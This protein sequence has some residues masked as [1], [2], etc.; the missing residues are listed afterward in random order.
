MFSNVN[1]DCYG[2]S[3][4]GRKRQS[5]EDRFLI[6]DLSRH[7]NICETNLDEARDS[8]LAGDQPGKLFVVADGVGGHAGGAKASALVVQSICDFVLNSMH[9]FLKLADERDEDFRDELAAGIERCQRRLMLE[10][11][12]RPEY[13]DMATT[14]TL[15][16]LVWPRMYVVHVGDSRCYLLRDGHLEQLTTDHTVA[17]QFVDGGA[18]QKNAARESPW[19]HIIWNCLGGDGDDIAPEV[20]RVDLRPRDL[21]LL[22]TDGLTDKLTEEELTELLTSGQPAESITQALIDAANDRGGADNVT[23]I[24]GH[25]AGAPEAVRTCGT[26]GKQTTAAA[27]TDTHPDIPRSLKDE[28]FRRNPGAF[29]RTSSS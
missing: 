9:R 11:Q 8:D 15:A 7:M 5:N 20:R 17:Q 3:H 16:Y 22:C 28:L 18:M 2:R 19:R 25:F 12:A 6:A 21:V 29:K 14:L 13:R 1:A 4:V 24:V 23:A 10:K 26:P 27:I